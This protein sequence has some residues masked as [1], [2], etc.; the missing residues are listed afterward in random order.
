MAPKDYDRQ[1]D[2]AMS[3]PP[4]PTS[5]H[6]ITTRCL[7]CGGKISTTAAGVGSLS[8][9][10]ALHLIA[11]AKCA[12]SYVAA[13]RIVT[14]SATTSE[15]AIAGT[16]YTRRPNTW[17]TTWPVFGITPTGKFTEFAAFTAKARAE[18]FIE[19]KMR[20]LRA[21]PQAGGR[22]PSTTAAINETLIGP[23][24]AARIRRLLRLGTSPRDISDRFRSVIDAMAEEE[25]ALT[26]RA[27]VSGDI[28]EDEKAE[29][30]A[31]LLRKSG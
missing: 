16:L 28:G 19:L 4:L 10:L 3:S 20:G 5:E 2:F 27:F 26:R 6:E 30:I 29:R 7:G 18:A 31:Q 24:T 13:N 23:V 25:I 9:A 1:Q 14:M 21:P 15:L 22:D 11:S 12:E 8:E 17:A